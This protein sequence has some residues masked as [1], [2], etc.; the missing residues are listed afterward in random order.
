MTSTK[1]ETRKVE[2]KTNTLPFKKQLKSSKI[3]LAAF[4]IKNNNNKVAFK[5][6]YKENLIKSVFFLKKKLFLQLLKLFTKEKK[7][8]EIL[9]NKYN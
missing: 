7:Y 3:H 4:F 6:K 1:A 2:A 5:K 9:R 8:Y